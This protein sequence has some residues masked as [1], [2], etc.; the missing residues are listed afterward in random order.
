VNFYLD[1]SRALHGLVQLRE[2]AQVAAD[3]A[4][5]GGRRDRQALVDDGPCGNGGCD[6][7]KGRPARFVQERKFKLRHYHPTG[8]MADTPEMWYAATQQRDIH[9][10]KNAD[11]R[12]CCV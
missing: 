4:G 9:G 3:D 7:A 8:P 12:A 1:A 2:D 5:N 11:R 10:R 6:L